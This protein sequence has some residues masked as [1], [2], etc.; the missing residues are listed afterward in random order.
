MTDVIMPYLSG[1]ELAER[2]ILLHP[3]M[4]VLYVLGYTDN[5]IVHHGVLELGLFFLQKPY[6]PTALTQ[7]VREVL[8]TP[9]RKLS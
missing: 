5:A 3:E 2:L 9:H 4:K 7:K 6:S 1:R 8:D